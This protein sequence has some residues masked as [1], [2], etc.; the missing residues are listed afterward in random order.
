V[1]NVEQIQVAIVSSHPL[2]RRFLPYDQTD[3]PNWPPWLQQNL[4]PSC[5][6]MDI[7]VDLSKNGQIV[8]VNLGGT[9]RVKLAENPTT[10]YHWHIDNLDT[11]LLEV[12]SSEYVPPQSA[13][14]GA[15]G[16]RVIV[17]KAK[18]IGSA[19]LE[20]KNWR[21]WQGP[22]SSIARAEYRVEIR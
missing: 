9:L 22:S 14:P 20:L 18:N 3:S 2:A 17:I 13:A 12:I 7:V 16:L 5:I 11:D 21:A 4:T 10:G 19:R 6:Q 8:Q 15:G 1:K